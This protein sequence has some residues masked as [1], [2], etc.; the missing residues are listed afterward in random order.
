MDAKSAL[1]FFSVS[2]S[3]TSRWTDWGQTTGQ[4]DWWINNK[5]VKWRERWRDRERA[6]RDWPAYVGQADGQTVW[7]DRQINTWSSYLEEWA[8]MRWTYILSDWRTKKQTDS[9]QVYWEAL[10]KWADRNRDEQTWHPDVE[11][12]LGS[13]RARWREDDASLKTIDIGK[14]SALKCVC[15]CVRV[16]SYTSLCVSLPFSVCVCVCVC[17]CCSSSGL[18]LSILCVCVLCVCV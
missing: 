3:R 10:T 15:R 5:T 18:A 2:H 12:G 14:D 13:T 16:C 11:V 9:R 8:L 7:T 4:T 17:V 6:K 1:W